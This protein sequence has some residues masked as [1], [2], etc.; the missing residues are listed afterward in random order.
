MLNS[1]EFV[2]L[3]LKLSRWYYQAQIRDAGRSNRDSASK[4]NLIT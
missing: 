2:I 4:K 1:L 3:K